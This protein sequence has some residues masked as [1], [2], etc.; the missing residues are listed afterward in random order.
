MLINPVYKKELKMMARSMQ[1]PALAVVF[2]VILSAVAIIV[3]Y[4][5][6]QIAVNSG[7]SPYNNMMPLY[8]A[9]LSIEV[10]MF[11]LFVPSAAGGSVAGERERQTL[12]I[13]LASKMTV[14]GIILGKLM[15]CISLALLLGISSL[16]VLAITLMYG[17][18]GLADIYQSIIYAGFLVLLIGCVGV[19]CSCCFKKTTFASVA[20]YGILIFLTLGTVLLVILLNAAYQLRTGGSVVD[21]YVYAAGYGGNAVRGLVYIWLF[22]PAVTYFMVLFGQLGNIRN[23]ENFLLSLGAA[24]EV[25]NHWILLSILAQIILMIVLF[26]LSIQY[27]DPQ[28]ERFQAGRKILK[29][30]KR[31]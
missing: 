26:I 10:F 29:K 9:I 1:L 3:L 13:L 18:I 5:I 4:C 28:N 19:F 6:R 31:Q 23:I 25:T 2:N 8:M 22:N 27:L 20:S 24:Q 16:P 15:S 14:P 7:T 11:F 12:D 17:G 30:H 21:Y